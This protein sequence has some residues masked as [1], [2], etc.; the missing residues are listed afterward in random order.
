MGWRRRAAVL[1][2]AVT[3]AVYLALAV[4]VLAV[5]VVAWPVGLLA[6]IGIT[7]LSA[8]YLPSARRLAHRVVASGP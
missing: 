3:G 7:A 8:G 6:L 2:L 5:I 1:T 4:G